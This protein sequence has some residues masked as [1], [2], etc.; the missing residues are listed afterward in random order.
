MGNILRIFWQVHKYL[1]NIIVIGV[2]GEVSGLLVRVQYSVQL[3]SSTSSLLLYSFSIASGR[4]L[5]FRL[6]LPLP[7]SRWF[8]RTI[9]PFLVARF[10]MYRPFQC[11]TL[12]S[13]SLYIR[14]NGRIRVRSLRCC[15]V[16]FYHSMLTPR[17]SR[18]LGGLIFVN[19]RGWKRRGDVVVRHRIGNT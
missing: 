15:S 10:S 19:Q 7:R 3:F 5:R 12:Y 17:E 11:F 4:L 9:H 14:T 8:S 6:L 2:G 16:L 13:H 18:K 1:T